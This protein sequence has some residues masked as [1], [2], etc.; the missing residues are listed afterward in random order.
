MYTASDERDVRLEQAAGLQVAIH[1][2]FQLSALAVYMLPT[3]TSISAGTEIVGVQKCPRL[4]STVKV[5]WLYYL[6]GAEVSLRGARG[7]SNTYS[8]CESYLYR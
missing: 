3:C 1:M 5:Q 4:H 8:S 2:H 7:E 6:K